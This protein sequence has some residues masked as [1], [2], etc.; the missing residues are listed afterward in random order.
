MAATPASAKQIAAQILVGVGL[1]GI[2]YVSYTRDTTTTK[3]RVRKVEE[4]RESL[5]RPQLADHQRPGESLEEA[6][7]KE[8]TTGSY[9][10]IPKRSDSAGRS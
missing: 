10:G 4:A 3:A 7:G 8:P 6:L 5:T 9:W 2:V 1:A